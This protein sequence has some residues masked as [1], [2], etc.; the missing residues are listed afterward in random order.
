MS[1]F[2]SCFV[3]ILPYINIVDFSSHFYLFY[4]V[5]YKYI[6]LGSVLQMDLVS[7]YISTLQMIVIDCSFCSGTTM[8]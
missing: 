3:L 5:A 7:I 2:F 1:T 6:C 8:L 4:I